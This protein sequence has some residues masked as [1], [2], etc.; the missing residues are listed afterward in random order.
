MIRGDSVSTG[1][2]LTLK[3]GLD[4]AEDGANITYTWTIMNGQLPSGASVGE[5]IILYVMTAL[6]IT[7]SYMQ[8]C[9]YCRW[10]PSDI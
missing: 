10:S 1:G 5:G 2:T 9:Y 4:G 8:C 6:C 7:N 3:C